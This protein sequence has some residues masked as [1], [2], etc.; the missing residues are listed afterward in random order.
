M[1]FFFFFQ[2]EDG[3]RDRD[4]T[5]VQTCALPIWV[6][7]GWAFAPPARPIGLQAVTGR[8]TIVPDPDHPS[9]SMQLV[10]EQLSLGGEPPADTVMDVEELG[11]QAPILLA[12]LLKVVFAEA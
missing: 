5:G 10:L 12:A 3:I 11:A 9:V 2:A 7:T 1:C 8:F 6:Q 4:V